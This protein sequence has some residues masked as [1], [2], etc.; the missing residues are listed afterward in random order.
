MSDTA[1]LAGGARP[2]PRPRA[3]QAHAGRA[4]ATRWSCPRQLHHRRAWGCGGKA[5]HGPARSARRILA[6]PPRA[7]FN[8]PV[9]A[10]A[11]TSR[12]SSL[13]DD[14][15]RLKLVFVD[16]RFDAAAS[17]AL[18]GRRR[19]RLSAAED[20]RDHWA[21]DLYG[22]WNRRQNPVKRPFAA[23]NTLAAGRPADP[24][25]RQ[26]HAPGA[27]PLPPRGTGRPMCMSTTSSGWNL[28]RK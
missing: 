9:R 8:A 24:G 28:G 18:A 19:D 5:S 1:V 2:R 23:L 25:D 10:L 3:A 27:Y 14:I 13:F 16:G 22:N 26:G 7:P 12:R 20:G 15:D 4:T 17:D 6:L 11:Y 21:G